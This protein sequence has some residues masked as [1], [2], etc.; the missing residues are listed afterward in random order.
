MD[1]GINK[2]IKKDLRIANL[3]AVTELDDE[4]FKNSSLIY[5]RKKSRNFY[6]KNGLV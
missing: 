5:E 6:T 3:Q 2:N 4:L 1:A